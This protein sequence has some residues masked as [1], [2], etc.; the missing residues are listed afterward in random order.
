MTSIAHFSMPNSIP[1]SWLYILTA[2][3]RVFSSI[4]F[5]AN[6]LMSSMYIGWLIFSCDLLSLYTSAHFLNMLFS[7]IMTI[8]NSKGDSAKSL[9]GS[10]FQLCFFL[11]LFAPLY[12][13]SW[14]VRW[15]L[16]LHVISCIFWDSVL[17]SL[18]GPYH[19][20]FCCLSRP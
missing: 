17:S 13:F 6:N 9:L 8:M 12:M 19:I 5:F 15:S 18:V 2:C 20:P 11:L 10:L 1:M 7:G 16:W 4:S 14:S 3:M